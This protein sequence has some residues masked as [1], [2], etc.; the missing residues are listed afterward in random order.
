[1]TSPTVT[2]T[3]P[4]GMAFASPITDHFPS[5]ATLD[6]PSL[7]VVS[8]YIASRMSRRLLNSTLK[9][10][11]STTAYCPQQEVKRSAIQRFRRDS[12]TFATSVRHAIDAI[13]QE[14]A[15]SMSSFQGNSWLEVGYSDEA[16]FDIANNSFRDFGYLFARTLSKIQT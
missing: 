2:I 6:Q 14:L 8:D 15:G 16:S 1:M 7:S 9:S 5:R 4:D 3:L 12:T 10:L 11:S 13:L